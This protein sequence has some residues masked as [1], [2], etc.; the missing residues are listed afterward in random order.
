MEDAQRGK[1][2]SQALSSLDSHRTPA[3]KHL[4]KQV[5][6]LSLKPE[7]TELVSV[8]TEPK[9]LRDQAKQC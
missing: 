2:T 8:T 4:T 3:D 7:S 5:T 1:P 9:Q 6:G